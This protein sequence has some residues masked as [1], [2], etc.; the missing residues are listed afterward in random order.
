MKK[1]LI[2]LMLGAFALMASG[3]NTVAG[4]GKDLEKVGEKMQDKSKK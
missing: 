4:F 2:A 1:T 3:C